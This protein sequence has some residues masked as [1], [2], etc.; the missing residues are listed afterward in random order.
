MDEINA[1]ESSIAS[2]G[3]KALALWIQNQQ[4]LTPSSHRAFFR[5][6]LSPRAVESYIYG[7]PGPKACM[8]NAHFR[9]FAFT[10]KDLEMSRS[11]N[12]QIAGSTGMPLTP[13]KIETVSV[14]GVNHYALKFGDQV[15]T[16][17]PNP[18]QYE[19][20]GSTVTLG[21]GS[22]TL[23]NLDEFVGDNN[24]TV[25]EEGLLFKVL[26]G[27]LCTSSYTNREFMNIIDVLIIMPFMQTT[28]VNLFLYRML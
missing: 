28:V 13:M 15:R 1:L 8:T 16:V 25:L 26:V 23:C 14:A 21:D 11:A 22:Y 19:D 24:G 2:S 18:L 4:S 10:Y 20:N 6:R 3:Q 7:I 9:R 5:E 27:D 17:L 12:T